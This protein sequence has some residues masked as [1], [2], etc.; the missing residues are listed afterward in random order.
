MYGLLIWEVTAR[1]RRGIAL[2]RRGNVFVDGL[3]ETYGAVR[4]LRGAD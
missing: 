1:R 4:R 3:I 2:D